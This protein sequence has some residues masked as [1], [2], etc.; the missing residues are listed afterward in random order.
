MEEIPTPEPP[1][2]KVDE[3]W[4]KRAA[5]EKA[6]LAPAAKAAAPAAAKPAEAPAAPGGAPQAA[7]PEEPPPQPGRRGGG[8]FEMLVTMLVQQASMMLGLVSDPMTGER[9][10]D[11]GQ[12]KMLID[13]LATLKIKTKGN[14][15]AQEDR[16]LN[17]A[18]GELQMEF[19]ALADAMTQQA[20]PGGK[21]KP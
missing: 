6:K 17:A 16:F 2:K 15:T 18:L 12:A 11:L 21:K 20:K 13:I 14:L 7:P 9:Y 4:K 3:D 8:P 10:Q 5:D 19:V 1:K